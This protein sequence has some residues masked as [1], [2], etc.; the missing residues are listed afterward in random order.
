MGSG[1]LQTRMFSRIVGKQRSYCIQIKYLT[2]MMVE[3]TPD[4]LSTS[5][6]GAKA[7]A[8]FY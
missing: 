2:L 6:R 4:Q 1:I 3:E 8:E 5:L 7:V